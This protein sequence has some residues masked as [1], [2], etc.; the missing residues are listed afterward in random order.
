MD[1]KGE[2]EQLE[3][4]WRELAIVGLVLGMRD[5]YN[6]CERDRAMRLLRLE[7]A[8]RPRDDESCGEVAS[9]VLDLAEKVRTGELVCEVAKSVNY[10]IGLDVPV[11][12]IV[13]TDVHIR[14]EDAILEPGDPPLDWGSVTNKVPNGCDLN[15]IRTVEFPERAPVAPDP[16]PERCPEC[17][18]DYGSHFRCILKRGHEGEHRLEARAVVTWSTGGAGNVELKLPDLVG[19]RKDPTYPK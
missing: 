7:A 18:Q 5:Q 1:S 11:E 3:L 14:P 17:F 6:R 2:K 16:E 15:D 8:I 12:T 19:V 4:S 9:R 10:A 13:E